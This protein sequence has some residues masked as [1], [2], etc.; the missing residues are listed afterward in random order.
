MIRFFCFSVRPSGLT[1]DI[2]Q[3]PTSIGPRTLGVHLPPDGNFKDEFAHSLEQAKNF[4]T[5][6]QKAPVSRREAT[7]ALNGI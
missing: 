1:I 7:L 2:D 4:A 6:A 3:V 5:Q